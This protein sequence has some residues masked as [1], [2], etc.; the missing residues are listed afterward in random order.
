MEATLEVLGRKKEEALKLLDKSW[1]S[2]VLQ[3]FSRVYRN[4]QRAFTNFRKAIGKFLLSPLICLPGNI[5]VE[6]E[7]LSISSIYFY[8]I[9]YVILIS[10]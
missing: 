3:D 5:K 8:D 2:E 10:V 6:R 7:V 4:S 9:Y 1:V